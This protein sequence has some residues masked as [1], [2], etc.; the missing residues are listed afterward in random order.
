MAT[1]RN[2]KVEAPQKWPLTHFYS[3]K[4]WGTLHKEK[5]NPLLWWGISPMIPNRWAFNSLPSRCQCH[6]PPHSYSP[7]LCA[8]KC[9]SH[10]HLTKFRRTPPTL[11]V[12]FTFVYLLLCYNFPKFM[13]NVAHLVLFVPLRF[14]HCGRKSSRHRC[15][16]SL[17]Q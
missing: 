7:F 5:A 13:C 9:T 16:S 4:G 12:P 17:D 11:P 2:P 1:Q 8:H 6:C 3:T 15:Y 10:L 14:S